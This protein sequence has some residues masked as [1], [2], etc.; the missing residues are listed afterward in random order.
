[1]IDANRAGAHSLYLLLKNGARGVLDPG[2]LNGTSPSS[3]G[4]QGRVCR[5]FREAALKSADGYRMAKNPEKPAPNYP[6][7][8]NRSRRHRHIERARAYAGEA[9]LARPGF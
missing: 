9:Q 6:C 4:S 3:R 2:R 1:K 7:A 5:P 8:E